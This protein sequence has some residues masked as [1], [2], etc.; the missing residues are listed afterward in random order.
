MNTR[1]TLV[2][3]EWLDHCSRG[4]SGWGTLDDVVA[5][6]PVYCSTVGFVISETKDTVTLASTVADSGDMLLGDLCIL[7]KAVV[8][9][10]RLVKPKRRYLQ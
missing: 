5:L 6:E 1:G 4:D 2:Y 10:T 3:V 7:K 8:R 9:R